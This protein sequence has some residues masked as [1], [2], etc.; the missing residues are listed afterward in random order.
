M[1][2]LVARHWDH[3]SIQRLKF[4]APHLLHPTQHSKK[5][6]VIWSLIQER[7]RHNRALPTRH[8]SL[9]MSNSVLTSS[10][11]TYPWWH[12]KTKALLKRS[13][14]W[15]RIART[16]STRQSSSE[17]KHTRKWIS[18]N[19]WRKYYRLSVCSNL[20]PNSSSSASRSWLQMNS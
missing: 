9:S 2:T 15:C 16:L 3:W 12:L 18:M 19:C 8:V 17:W 11:W 13:K 7:N 14:R 20:S 6:A 1:R 4:S 5:T 10:A